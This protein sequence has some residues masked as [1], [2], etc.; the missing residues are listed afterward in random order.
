MT[1]V[2]W[3]PIYFGL[4]SNLNDPA[5]QLRKAVLALQ[6]LA[7]VR[8]YRVS[9]VVRSAPVD[10]SAQPDYLNIV[11][12]G[13]THLQPMTLMHEC[14]RIEVAHGRDHAAKRWSAR[15]LDIDLLALGDTVIDSASLTLP[16]AQLAVRAFVVVPLA[17]I[18]PEF[19]VPEIG[20]VQALLTQVERASVSA[21]GKLFPDGLP[22]GLS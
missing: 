20:P 11:A 1:R 13:M 10:G 9:S 17:Q 12:A 19:N 7:A 18:A 22:N 8:L 16:H 4:G 21:A 15:P 3:Q 14:Q 5:R 6:K 2:R